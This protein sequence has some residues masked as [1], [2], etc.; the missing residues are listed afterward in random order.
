[1]NKL[2][3]VT[4]S[5]RPSVPSVWDIWL[6]KQLVNEHRLNRISIIFEKQQ[7]LYYKYGAKILTQ[8][9]LK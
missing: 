4:I 1:M 9:K 5:P 8:E 7:M 3:W 6:Q 2:L